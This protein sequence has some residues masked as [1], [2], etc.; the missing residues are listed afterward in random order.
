MGVPQSIQVIRPFWL[1]DPP[2]LRIPQIGKVSN[3]SRYGLKPSQHFGRSQEMVSK[4]WG[5][6]LQTTDSIVRVP[7][8]DPPNPSGRCLESALA[9]SWT[10][11]HWMSIN[12]VA[13][14]PKSSEICKVMG[15][16]AKCCALPIWES[17]QPGLHRATIHFNSPVLKCSN[18]SFWKRWYTGIPI[19]PPLD[20]EN[21]QPVDLG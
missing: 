19:K 5:R 7:E 10:T 18:S 16:T 11:Y 17:N 9:D 14:C 6:G 8:F 20:K 13:H 12:W 21:Y 2:I 1:G 4:D 15:K 3:L